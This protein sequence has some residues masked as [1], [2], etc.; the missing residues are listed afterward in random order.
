M[1]RLASALV[2]TVLLVMLALPAAA[3]FRDDVAEMRAQQIAAQGFLKTIEWRTDY[4]EAQLAAGR[5]Y[6]V[7][8]PLVEFNGYDRV[9]QDEAYAA[10]TIEYLIMMERNGFPFDQEEFDEFLA[11]REFS[12][13][14]LRPQMEKTLFL[15]QTMAERIRM[16]IA[17][18]EAEIAK[19]TAPPPPPPPA[20]ENGPAPA[21]PVADDGRVCL[22]LVGV[23]RL[24]GLA[25]AASVAPDAGTHVAAHRG[26]VDGRPTDNALTWTAPPLRLCEGDTFVVEMNALNN[27]PKFEAGWAYTGAVSF[28]PTAGDIEVV[29]C[30]NPPPH[31][32]SANSAAVKADASSWVNTCTYRVTG[33]GSY[34]SPKGLLAADLSA[35]PAFGK[36]TY[37]YVAR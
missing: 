17:H 13:L 30:S 36:V 21:Q 14:N 1:T 18:T 23:E 19:L 5:V 27:A 37:L 4:L 24:F 22:E 25:D 2:Q 16:Q 20:P 9:T 28:H 35:K 15:L 26:E 31:G 3:Q 11:I 8:S 33:I 10:I 29:S 32:Q 7:Y 12:M 34:S 6:Q